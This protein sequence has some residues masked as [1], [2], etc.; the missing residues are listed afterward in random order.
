[1]STYILKRILQGIPVILGVL[2]ISFILMYIAPGDPVLALVGDYYDEDTLAQ[3]RHQLGLDR[4]A[5]TQY[6]IF[7]KRILSGDLGNSFVTQRP[8]LDDI[9]EKI[10]F[11][12]QLATAAMFIA[13]VVGVLLGILSAL[14]KDTI[15][16]KASIII[17]LA[18]VSAP[19]FWV[20]LLLILW[21][22]VYLQW[23]PPTGYGGLKFLV[24]PAIALGTR[25]LAM[26][27][28]LTRAFMLDTMN[29]DYIVTARS[30]GLSERIVIFKHAMKN[31]A[32]PLITIIG[33]D[34]GSYM[35]GAVLTESIFGWPGV[36]RFALNA[37]MKR[38]FPAI[39]GSVLF[40][41]LI[42]VVV[43]IIVDIIYAWADPRVRERLVD[44]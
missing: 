21:V 35:S 29:E 3:L 28:R 10:P 24:L 16:D 33:L 44:R 38:D 27:T 32:I 9:L 19:V 42:F 39:Q 36:G 31:L 30:K 15:W 8:V 41:A 5:I 1:M 25:S 20:A 11:T 26:M 43:N 23:L 6:G 40:M 17:S 13:V 18:G 2:T 7:M 34:F 22:G 14:K 4:S 37:I 12:L